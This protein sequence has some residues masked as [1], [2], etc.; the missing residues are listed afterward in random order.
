MLVCGLCIR[1]LFCQKWRMRSRMCPPPLFS[2]I[3]IVPFREL[4]SNKIQSTR[5]T[6]YVQLVIQTTHSPP[7][8]SQGF[9]KHPS[10]LKLMNELLRDHPLKMLK[11][12]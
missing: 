1:I 8:S 9:T 4:Q 3:N 10:Y 11:L 7:E 2:T 6:P 5:Y 12:I